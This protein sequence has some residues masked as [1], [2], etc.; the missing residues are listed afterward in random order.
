[1]VASTNEAVGMTSTSTVEVVRTSLVA[2]RR[3]GIA[4]RKMSVLEYR[5]L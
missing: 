1:M 5:F 2:R 3:E 4:R